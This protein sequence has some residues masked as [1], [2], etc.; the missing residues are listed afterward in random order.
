MFQ[1]FRQAVLW[2][3]SCHRAVDRLEY[4]GIFRMQLFHLV[5]AKTAQDIKAAMPSAQEVEEKG[6]L[7]NFI[8]PFNRHAQPPN[9]WGSTLD[10]HPSWMGIVG[11]TSNKKRGRWL[12]EKF[13][14]EI[15]WNYSGNQKET[16]LFSIIGVLFLLL[17]LLTVGFAVFM[18][19]MR[20][21]A[22]K[23]IKKDVNPL[24]GVEEVENKNPR[25]DSLEQSYDYMG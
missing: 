20:S 13:L 23:V 12:L 18:C 19:K 9:V 14:L 4:L 10:A 25:S 8:T 21:S 2:R 24:Y 6:T 17:I 1:K 16:L 22:K 11:H 3:V 7:A 5:M 15:I